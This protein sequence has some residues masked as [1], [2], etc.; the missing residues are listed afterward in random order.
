MR[1]K[2]LA[3]E[4][5]WRSRYDSINDFERMLVREGTTIVKFYLHI[6]GEEQLE[7]FR[8]RLERTDKYWKWSKN[9]MK[10]REHWDEYQR[11]YEDAV[12]RDQHAVGAVVRRARGPSLV[13]QL[14]RRARAGR[15]ADGHGARVPGAAGGREGLRRARARRRALTAG[16]R[17]VPCLG[18]PPPL[19]SRRCPA[20]ARRSRR[21][22]PP[23]SS[24]SPP[25]AGRGRASGPPG[26]AAPPTCSPPAR[27]R[28]PP[29]SPRRGS[30]APASMPGRGASPGATARGSSRRAG[31]SSSAAP[32]RARFARAPAG[33]AALPLRRAGPRARPAAGADRRRRPRGDG[34]ARVPR[35]G[36]LGPARPPGRRSRAIID[37]AVDTTHPDL[38][39]VRVIGDARVTDFH[40]TAVAS[41][42]G[43]RGNAFGVAG[44]FPGAPL[45]SIGTPLRTASLVRSISAAVRGGAR[46][47]N[48]SL[49]S[50]SPSFAML[51]EIAYAISQDVLVVAAAGN[52]RFTVLPDGTVNPVMFPAAFPHVVSVSSM[53]PMGASSDFSTSNG[54]VD[55]AAPGEGVIAAVPR[56]ADPDGNARRLRAPGRDEL[57]RARR[58]GRRRLAAGGALRARRRPG[59]RPAAPHRRRP[60]A[61]RLGHGLRLRPDRHRRGPGGR[62]APDRLDGGQ[63]RHRVGRRPALRAAGRV[64]AARARAHERRAGPG[65][66]LEG[67]GRR[68]SLPDPRSLAACASRCAPRRAPTRASRCSAACGRSIYRERGLVAASARGPGRT[69]RAVVTNA[70]RRTQVGYAVVYAPGRRGRR[71]DAPYLLRIARS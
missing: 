43:A 40:G 13:P 70:G 64:P 41:M 47:I 2:D 42:A 61:R 55:V 10:E 19:A 6:S 30:S 1:V 60:P 12:E 4:E 58:R 67:P 31:P 14:R 7:K 71:I 39:G 56:G 37:S 48:M 22:P 32:A 20:S 45:L 50:P 25:R 28:S 36:A 66:P 52:D 57:R 46:V 62:R 23:C 44:I 68:L 53:G 34:L 38:A 33:G 9:D 63:R 69:E 24:A 3:P 16:R 29:R 18:R 35:A 65:R 15:D 54:A 8:E 26:T 27:P 5:L 17:P 51:V 49:G 21:S 59:G 11:A